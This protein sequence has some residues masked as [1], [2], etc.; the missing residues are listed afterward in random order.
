MV[1]W[2]DQAM[3]ERLAVQKCWHHWRGAP[4]TVAV[5]RGEGRRHR[6]ARGITLAS[7]QRK[8]SARMVD[9]HAGHECAAAQSERIDGLGL[10][11][12]AGQHAVLGPAVLQAQVR[13]ELAHVPLVHQ[14]QA[15]GPR[16]YALLH[17][18]AELESK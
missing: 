1:V 13:Y 7:A 12:R 3:E 9:R 10:A 15:A 17:A 5:C 14:E 4:S 18:Q 2:R 6:C 8:R 16:D 11:I